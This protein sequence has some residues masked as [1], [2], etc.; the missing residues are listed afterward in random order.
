MAIAALAG[1]A[2]LC[3]LDIKP[4]AVEFQPTGSV[5]QAAWMRELMAHY[6]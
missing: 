2:L 5:R 1:V 3:Y 4:Y 6:Y